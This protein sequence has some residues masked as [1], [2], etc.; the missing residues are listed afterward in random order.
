MLMM[1][2]TSALEI[3]FIA[4]SLAETSKTSI[5]GKEGFDSSQNGTLETK[6]DAEQE[7][8]LESPSETSSCGDDKW[9][10]NDTNEWRNFTYVDGNKTRLILGV[11]GEKPASLVELEKI[12]AKHEARIVDTVS[13]GGHVRALVVE[14]LLKSVTAF[15]EE[16]HSVGVAS[17]MEP[18]MKVQ[19]QLV[20]NDP[21]W[22]VQWGPRKIEAD[23]AW[24]TTV[25]DHSV[26]V[27]VIDTGIYYTHPDLAANYVPLG[28]DWVNNDIDPMDDNGHGTHCAGIIAAVINNS[29]GIAG[30]AQVQVM[31][32]KVLDSSGQGYLDWIAN[33][34]INA[35]DSGAKIISMS[36]GAY[37]YSQLL[38]DAVKYAYDRGV[39]VIA[40]AGNDNTNTKLYPAGY[41]EVIAVAATDQND[42]EAW[43]SNWGD[44]IELSAPGVD[45]YSTVPW[46]YDYMSGTS[47]ACPHVAGEAALVWSL[48]PNKTRDWVRE[49]LRSTADDLGDPGFDVYYGYGRVNARKAAEQTA[50]AHELMAYG[51]ATPLYVKPAASGTINGT[52]LDFGENDETD[53]TVELLAN[54]TV[55]DSTVIGF[56]ASGNSVSVGFTWSPVAQGLYNV[57]LYVEPVPG[58]RDLENNV[59]WKYIYVGFPVKAVVVHS[60]GNVYGQIITNWQVLNNQWYLFGGTMVNVDYTTLNK[61]NITYEDITATGADVL[62]ISCACD[63]YSGW[64]FTDSEIEAIA[65][66]VYE[67]HG[68]VV[69]AGTLSYEV[70]N[71]NKLAA[72]L[73]LNE[74]IRWDSTST[75]L[76]H[77][78]NTTHPILRDVPNPLVFPQ[79]ATVLPT[80]GRWD[81]NEL[82]GGKY[83][84]LGHYQE[85]AIVTFRGLVYI[86]PLLEIIPPYYHHQL[87]L[88]YNAITWSRYQKPE[89]ELVVSLKAPAR[90]KP[91]ESTLL[92][93][94]VSNLGR[95]N[96]TDVEL[97]LLINGALISSVNIPELLVGSSHTLSYLWTPTV[98]GICNVTAYAPPKSG[99]EL[100]QNNIATEMAMVL[101]ISVRNA[102]V[103]SDDYYVEPSS[104]YVIVA[105]N[106]L[107]INYTYCSDD[108]WG[109][110]AALVSQPWD[111]VIVDHCNYYAMGQYWNELEEYVRNGGHLVLSTFDIDGSNSEPTTLWDTLGVRWVS[112]MG[113]PEPVYRWLSSHAIFTF[114]NT[115]GDLTSYTQGYWDGGDHVAT[116]T[117]TA[118]A[119]FTT[120]PAEDYAA[121]VVGNTYPTVLFSFRPDE[122]RYDQDRDGKLDAIELW[123]NAIVY[124]AR[125]Y[126]HDLAVSLEAPKSLGSGESALLNAT[127]SNRGLSNETDV[128]LQLL[129]N[130]TVV[131]SVLISEL[132]TGA[133]YTLRYLWTPKMAFLYYNVTAYALPVLGEDFVLN[134]G[135]TKMVY[136]SFYT[137]TYLQP[138]WIGGGVPMGWH[139][140]DASWSY[141]LPF[142]FLFYGV[143]YRAI[144]ISSNGLITFLNPD[145]NYSNSL[146]ALAGKLAIAPAWKDWATYDPY[147]IYIWQNSTHVGI[148]WYVRAYGSSVVANF[149]AILST[150][151][152]IQCNYGYNDGP[153]SP[154][155]GISNAGAG[156]MIAE[157]VGSLN[158]INTIVFT[159]FRPEHELIVYLDA[160]ARLEPDHS[161]LLNATVENRGLNNET[162]VE[163][164][165]LINGATVSSATIPQL[166]VRDSYVLTYLWTP[167]AEATYNVTA[168]APPVLGEN[169]TANNFA[170]EMVLVRYPPKLLVVDTPGAEDTGALD[171]LGHE[172]T[173]V[174]PAEFATV[175]LYQY[176]VLFIGWEPGDTLVDALLARASDIANW[177]EA[178]NGIV[179]LAEFYETNRWT[180]LPLFADG[181]YG[182]GD[183]VHILNPTHPVMSNLTDA[184]LSYWFNSYYGYFFSYD[185]SWETLAEGVEAAQPITMATTYG[186]GRI[187]ITDQDPDYYFYYWHQEGA[188]KLLRNMIEWATPIGRE[189]DL[190]V[191]LQAPASLELGNSA[192]INATVRNVGL[193]NETRIELYLLINGSVVNSTT[194]L[195]LLQG[196]SVTFTFLWTPTDTRNY[197]I[198]AYAPPVSEEEETSNNNVTK[199]VNVF[200]YTQVYLPHRWVGDGAPMDWHADDA[201][202]QYTLPFDFPFYG[203]YYRTI[204]ISSNGLI[205]FT[206]PD[207][208]CG[209]SIPDLA[210]KLAITP[211]W[212]DWVTYEYNYIFVWQNSTQIGIRWY[213]RWIGSYVHA[214]FEAIL[215]VDGTIQFNYDLNDGPVSATIGIS[216]GVNRILAED[217]TSLNHI[218][219]IL[220]LPYLVEHDVAVTNVMP[221]AYQVLVGESV[222]VTV[223][224]ENQGMIP[225]SF[226][227]T[228]YASQSDS[229]PAET[230]P[231][232]VMPVVDLSPETSISL[233]FT[234]ST[235]NFTAQDYAISAAAD[236]IPGE[237]DIYNNLCYDGTVKIVEAPVATFAY[238]PV[239]AIENIPVTFDAS[240]STPNGG[241]IAS[242]TWDFG[243]GNVTTTTD[244]VIAHAYDSHGTY[245]V[246]LTVMDSEGLIDSTWQLVEVWRHDVA[247]TDV[248]SD[249]TWV[250]Q[251][252]SV[253]LNVT[254]LNRG[255]FPENLAV[256]LYYNIT[257]NKIIG[258]QN[259]T[260]P[261][262]EN[263]TLSFVWDTPSVPYCHNYTITAVA[264]IPLDSNPADNALACGP[265]NVRIMGDINGDGKVDGKDLGATAQAFASYAPNFLYA[266]SPAHPRWNPDADLNLDNKIDGKD[267]GTIAE[268]F[269]K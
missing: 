262:G 128:E 116:T 141:T 64:E 223:V 115:V 172:Y 83:L 171:M 170:S 25:G 138:Q 119:G 44:W 188:G 58:E 104:R 79:V 249:R 20:P 151:G 173:L 155:I 183:M 161:A 102:L 95:N 4:P 250:F 53:V 3:T 154:T 234:W 47:M 232:G 16:V 189:H 193:N 179:A 69:T 136:V 142:D 214:D 94:T 15:A 267:L 68:L 243:D 157:D 27:A 197:N 96:E 100:T 221:F 5:F 230:Y 248:V 52:I 239:P 126:E 34:I 251:G 135:A 12:A 77:L 178:G 166:L 145:S 160:P 43:F 36:L 60:A 238:S 78:I 99:E 182:G 72:L 258:T 237:I 163:L 59:L 86:S 176:N 110:S 255:D 252:F 117:G 82:V 205:T 217:V 118:I 246:T 174:T 152:V 144:Y 164:Y 10:F 261:T 73:G 196:E 149:E 75:D 6:Q 2:L 257:V 192:L 236:I 256:T 204:Y 89:H 109:F 51:W 165:L 129:V 32:E 17:Y 28:Y 190:A 98:Q 71:N 54:D 92:N 195:T 42:N 158:Y 175:D 106:D 112:D 194:N 226:N 260:I 91:G 218:R 14:I 87:Q 209:N 247:I 84:A 62:I 41:D 49:W 231:I 203:T 227:V 38:H 132:F 35:T 13:M 46:G 140:D 105:L 211:A 241:Y 107:G 228:L 113:A 148:R 122:F 235:A 57:T 198:T 11:D 184:D 147:D 101:L 40:A 97:Q 199:E 162:N 61:D 220:F 201:S 269:G 143:Y 240:N 229:T 66:Y 139:A 80:D 268:N 191:S 181:S 55:I 81:S 121:V 124:S 167:K 180:W 70:P 156:D 146:H 26:L 210:G 169:A 233:T 215:N 207:S 206:S 37:D 103:Y 213:V 200:F 48:Y 186:A 185:S 265:I 208:S 63:P 216:N 137:R 114:P 177:A 159:P 30:L 202:W 134:N 19:A 123:E 131:D 242:F 224:A 108:P 254:I 90:V 212:D 74:A 88:L 259:I 187:A 85:S 9:N 21:Y 93:A 130:G 264:T 225:E 56:L 39:L 22:S 29:E 127:V 67:G 168:Y 266:A 222:D 24:N 133:S 23:W 263:R 33:G 219:S 65:R 8:T 7:R 253:S 50:P 120:S 45:I 1:I 245:N 153:V 244:P 111:L 76:L 18:N 125:G 31:A 150:D